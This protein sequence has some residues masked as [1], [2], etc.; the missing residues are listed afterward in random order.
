MALPRKRAI[1]RKKGKE[2]ISLY[3]YVEGNKNHLRY[4]GRPKSAKDPGVYRLF[5]DDAKPGT[6][7]DT[8][9]KMLYADLLTGEALKDAV[10]ICEPKPDDFIFP[11]RFVKRYDET[12]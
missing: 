12:D 3:D 5:F 4:V 8:L 11:S 1:G 9:C 7:S 2:E 10:A 6:K